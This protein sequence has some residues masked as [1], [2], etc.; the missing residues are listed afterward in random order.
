VTERNHQRWG[1][2]SW[3]MTSERGDGGIIFWIG[4]IQ[5]AT[6]AFV[7]DNSKRVFIHTLDNSSIGPYASM[8]EAMREMHRRLKSPRGVRE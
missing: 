7:R 6:L 3:V 2:G 5:V 1:P 8:S 4:E